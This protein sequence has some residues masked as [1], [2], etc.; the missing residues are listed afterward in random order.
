MKKRIL[1]FVLVFSMIASFATVMPLSARASERDDILRNEHECQWGYYRSNNRWF[2][3]SLENNRVMQDV[4]ALG[5]ISE[6]LEWYLAGSQKAKING[7]MTRVTVD[8]S[9]AA[10]PKTYVWDE[11]NGRSKEFPQILNDRKTIAGKNVEIEWY[12]FSV[13]DDFWYI[14]ND[15]TVF[16]LVRKYESDTILDDDNWDEIDIVGYKPSFSM[17]NG[18]KYVKFVSKSST[19]TTVTTPSKPRLISYTAPAKQIQQGNMWNFN[20]QII[21]DSK[22]K[23]IT[24]QIF[25]RYGNFDAN[26]KPITINDFKV[27]KT[28]EPNTNT[29][30]L[31]NIGNLIREFDG[32]TISFSEYPS[33]QMELQIN[34]VIDDGT[35]NG[36]YYM[37]KQD[38]FEIVGDDVDDMIKYAESFVNSKN[39][40]IY[41]A[42]GEKNSDGGY[43]FDCSS[44]TKMIYGVYGITLPRTSKEQ[45]QKGSSVNY[46]VDKTSKTI[47]GLKKGDLLYFYVDGQGHVEIY[48]GDNMV[49]HAKGTGKGIVKE[50]ISSWECNNIKAV[51]RFFK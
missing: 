42:N 23:K 20:G 16:K 10:D 11:G 22:I 50:K 46:Y 28:I 4:F 29:Y 39:R 44:F 40:Y 2:I 36:Q 21:S 48:A 12:Y 32:K 43:D 1:S 38:F 6:R 49:I 27:K 31:K 7:D 47:S 33:G 41:G 18:K 37:L 15:E 17:K 51:R 30:D 26:Y 3:S 35:P 24:V 5:Y 34:V 8:S 19:S 45:S 9:I 25:D 13:N 14:V